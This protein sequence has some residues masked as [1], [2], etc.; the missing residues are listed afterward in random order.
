VSVNTSRPL[1]RCVSRLFPAGK[2]SRNLAIWRREASIGSVKTTYRTRSV[3]GGV[4][5]EPE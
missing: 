2:S 1:S 3:Y 5:S 4:V